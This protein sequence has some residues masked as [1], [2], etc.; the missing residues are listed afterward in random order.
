MKYVR[1]ELT[2]CSRGV[3][4]S[5]RTGL[6]AVF[7]NPITWFLVRNGELEIQKLRVYV[8]INFL[9]KA[10]VVSW[11]FLSHPIFILLS[12]GARS[13]KQ[14]TVEYDGYKKEGKL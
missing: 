14:E 13:N 10:F 6:Y 8:I 2:S 3:R 4:C 1:S 12:Q 9:F 7:V 11:D 5:H